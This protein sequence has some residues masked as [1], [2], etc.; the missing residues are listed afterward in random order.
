MAQDTDEIED[1]LNSIEQEQQQVLNANKPSKNKIVKLED[2]KD[3]PAANLD[4]LDGKNLSNTQKVEVVSNVFK[5]AVN[6]DNLSSSDQMR[7]MIK[8][9]KDV[10]D[11]TIKQNLLAKLQSGGLKNFIINNPKILTFLVKML[12]HDEALPSL[13]KLTEDK[14]RYTTFAVAMIATFILGFILKMPLKKGA[15]GAMKPIVS[16][17]PRWLFIFTIRIGLFIFFFHNEA[18]P[19]VK[20]AL[21]VYRS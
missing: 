16:F 10:P 7:I 12:K 6:T 9:L 13:A 2:V 8:G 19:A 20:L 17:F 4:I 15:K 21:E 1:Q 11:D 14:K 5:F 18:G 3:H